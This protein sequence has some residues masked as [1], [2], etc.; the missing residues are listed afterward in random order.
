[1]KLPK[2]GPYRFAVEIRNKFW[3]KPRLLDLLRENN[4]ALAL[5]AHSYMPGP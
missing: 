1:M 4:V 2:V 5:Q 3:L